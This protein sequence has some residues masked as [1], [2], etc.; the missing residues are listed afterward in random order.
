M[1]PPTEVITAGT[2]T[3][4]RHD[5]FARGLYH[6]FINGNLVGDAFFEAPP[7]AIASQDDSIIM[8]TYKF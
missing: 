8:I 5:G 4:R 7:A 2:Q 6:F 3:A 1:L